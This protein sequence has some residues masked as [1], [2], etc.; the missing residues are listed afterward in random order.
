MDNPEYSFITE[1][2]NLKPDLVWANFDQISH[3]WTTQMDQFS[4]NLNK[5][6]QSH[7]PFEEVSH[8]LTKLRD[9]LLLLT[10]LIRR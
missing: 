10:Y 6:S 2:I 5:M 3:G 7:P 4:E 9:D 1:I 8:D